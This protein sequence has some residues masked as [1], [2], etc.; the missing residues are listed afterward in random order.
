MRSHLFCHLESLSFDSMKI[1]LK[2]LFSFINIKSKGEGPS[3]YRISTFWIGSWYVARAWSL[4]PH[5]LPWSKILKELL[6]VYLVTW[7]S[8]SEKSVLS[9]SWKFIMYIP[10]D[11]ILKKLAWY[12]LDL[13]NHKIPFL[14][15]YTLNFMCW[16]FISFII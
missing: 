10:K 11:L 4:F 8:K 7:L 15:F 3:F 2:A 12:F 9:F 5:C 16:Y 14:T 13:R 6:T 1:I